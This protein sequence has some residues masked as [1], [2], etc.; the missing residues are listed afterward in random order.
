MSKNLILTAAF[1]AL[2]MTAAHADPSHYTIYGLNAV[3]NGNAGATWTSAPDGRVEIVIAA[4][5]TT[6]GFGAKPVTMSSPIQVRNAVNGA[7]ITVAPLSCID[8][9]IQLRCTTSF[10]P[11]PADT[12][13]GR[14]FRPVVTIADSTGTKDFTSSTTVNYEAP[15]FIAPEE[16]N[17]Y[18]RCGIN[19]H[20]A[21]TSSSTIYLNP[22][23]EQYLEDDG[24]SIMQAGQHPNN[25]RHRKKLLDIKSVY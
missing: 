4:N 3:G 7:S 11:T 5:Y 8:Q 14:A 12:A 6:A 21:F 20:I 17:V 22:A 13:A 25:I 16:A 23:D 15:A 9:T 2:T 1:A 10:T 18:P 24:Y 19:N